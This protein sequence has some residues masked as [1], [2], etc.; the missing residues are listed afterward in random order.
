MERKSDK[1]L[2]HKTRVLEGKVKKGLE[3]A[4]KSSTITLSITLSKVPFNN[5][6]EDKIIWSKCL[7][8]ILTKSTEIKII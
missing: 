6:F 5:K 1:N 8:V 2:V 4:V 7:E 3:I